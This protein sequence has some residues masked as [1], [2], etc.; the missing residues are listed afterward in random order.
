MWEFSLIVSNFGH[1]IVEN[2]IIIIVINFFY[3]LR[4]HRIQ[5]CTNSCRPAFCWKCTQRS[6]LPLL[7][8][9]IFQ[10]AGI[11]MPDLQN[12]LSPNLCQNATVL[13]GKIRKLKSVICMQT[14]HRKIGRISLD[15]DSTP[16]QGL[17]PQSYRHRKPSR[18][19]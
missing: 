8:Q 4:N 2:K 9:G 19:K 15:R 1:K 3:P 14:L 11:A 17:L 7:Q 5:W 16:D 6:V 13:H 12:L 18:Q 10:I